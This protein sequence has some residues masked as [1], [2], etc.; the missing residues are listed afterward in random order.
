M[1]IFL[2]D[3]NTI[4][5]LEYIEIGEECPICGQG[6]IYEVKADDGNYGEYFVC[7]NGCGSYEEYDRMDCFTGRKRHNGV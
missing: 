7:C 1:C 6:T 5:R 3:P 2:V 4:L